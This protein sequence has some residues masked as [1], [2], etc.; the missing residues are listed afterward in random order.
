LAGGCGEWV[1][2]LAGYGEGEVAWWVA[3]REE[4]SKWHCS[5]DWD[6]G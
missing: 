5:S 2:S 4:W 1:V 3:W 6:R